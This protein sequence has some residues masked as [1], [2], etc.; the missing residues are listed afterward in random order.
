M[1]LS[2]NKRRMSLS[3]VLVTLACSIVVCI[4]HAARAAENAGEHIYREQCA[5]CHG[6]SGEGIEDKYPDPLAGDKSIAQLTKL[7][8]ETMP[9]DSDTKCS[10][11][12]SEQVAA[13]IYDTFY[14]ADARVRNKPAR[15]ELSRLT[16]RQE[17]NVVADLVGSFRRPLFWEN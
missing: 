4:A 15:I 17:Q 10:T 1:R 2:Q 8:Q 6:K 5:R 9:D 11:E 16:V 3:G 13:F 14:S 12:D 7:I